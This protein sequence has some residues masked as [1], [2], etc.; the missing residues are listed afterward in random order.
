MTL[1]DLPQITSTAEESARINRSANTDALLKT[2]PDFSA[3]LP[4]IQDVFWLRARDGSLSCKLADGQWL[5]GNSLP[6][7]TAAYMLRELQV[8][9]VV[10]CFLDVPHA[11]FLREA[12][13]RLRAGQSIIAVVPDLEQMAILLHC[14]DFST[15]ITGHRLWLAAGND[16]SAQL[17]EIFHQWP[18]L[19]TPNSFIKTPLTPQPLLQ[20]MIET[21]QQCFTAE[22]RNRTEAIAELIRREKNRAGD[23]KRVC[24]IA[25]STFRLW[26]PGAEVLAKITA[27]AE[28]N[29][30]AP[31]ILDTDLPTS[32]SPLALALAASNCDAVLS[33]NISRANAQGIVPMD[34]PWITWL[35]HPNIPQYTGA[36]NDRLLLADPAWKSRA[37][38]IG[39][40]A[41]RLCIAGWPQRSRSTGPRATGH[42]LGL[43]IDTRVV[44]PSRDFE[45][46]S[47]SLL[48]E[49]IRRRLMEDPFDLN[50]EPASYLSHWLARCN[51]PPGDL[52]QQLFIEQLIVPAYHQS[53]AN[54]LMNEK[55]PLRIHGH[56]WQ[57]IPEFAP[58]ALG[59]IADSDSFDTAVSGAQALLHPWPV[60]H[61]HPIDAV[62]KPVLR[63]AGK[64]RTKFLGE[65]GKICRGE[66]AP[67]EAV[68]SPL[69]LSLLIPS[70]AS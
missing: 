67:P 29:V 13:D 63:S 26:D 10:S 62:G 9:H 36:P 11:A 66:F 59:P 70:I 31:H 16:W 33:A 12:L 69:S 52:D 41:D 47:Q 34:T 51:V 27:T 35:T 23:K 39:W 25:P 1:L 49:T 30:I 38:Q 22:T 50:E 32:A 61:A 53:L 54:L 6:R 15:E 20:Q 48:W 14:E 21:A 58:A 45:L 42:G 24:L 17:T 40:P 8:S 43:I 28:A 46:S 64:T 65:A 44:E 19:P 55:I 4:E 68:N 56:G 57:D 2:Q 3:R 60:R 7:R 37:R 5:A 18:G